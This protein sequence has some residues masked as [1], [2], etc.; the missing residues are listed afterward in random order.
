MPKEE[1]RIIP[2]DQMATAFDADA[3]TIFCD[4]FWGV[5]SAEGVT[6]INLYEIKYTYDGTDPKKHIV[7]RLAISTE[8]FFKVVEALNGIKT[9]MENSRK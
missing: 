3:P 1:I 2:P 4:G 6:K 8:A 9:Q 7:A 5:T